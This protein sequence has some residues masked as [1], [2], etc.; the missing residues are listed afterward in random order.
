LAA[1]PASTTLTR[2]PSTRANIATAVAAML[3]ELVSVGV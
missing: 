3:A 1:D 2:T